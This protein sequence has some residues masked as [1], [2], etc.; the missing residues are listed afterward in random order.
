MQKDKILVA[1][2]EKSMREFLDIMLKKEG[3]KVTLASNGEEVMKL[4]EKDIFDLALVDIRMPR[5]DG[6]SVLK[7]IKSIS[8]E[9][10]V[11]VITAYASADTAIK[12]MKEGAYDYIM[13][14][15]KIEEIKLIIQNALEKKHLQNENLLLKQ[16]VRDRYHFENIIGQSSRMLD[17]YDLLEKVA[18][19]KTNILIAGESGTGKELAAKAIHYNSPRKDKP[20]VTLNCGA[21]PESLIET[22][23]FG[24]MKGAFT[25]AIST[26]KGLFEVA[27]EGTLFLDEISELPLM[28]QVKLL[29][30]LQDREFKRVG[31]T[32]DIRVDVR[33]ISATN[34]DLEEAVR[35]KQFREDLFYRLNVIQIKIPSL[36]E[37]KEDIPLLTSHFLKKYSEELGKQISQI[38]PEALRI[39]VQYD[40]PGNVRELQNIIE[41][42]VALETSQELTAQNLNSYI[43]EQLPLKRKPLDLEIPSEGVDLEKIVEDVERTLLLKALDRTK[44][45][46]KKAAELLHINF[47]SMRYRLEKYGLNNGE[48]S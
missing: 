28:M 40:Y 14:P 43:E 38:S 11:I 17:L 44:G 31:G 48:E 46:K 7:R 39:L 12:A 9:T 30:V 6:I 32:E 4:I 36:R 37:H 8:P 13:K 34:K 20:F 35:E 26:K 5:Q 22:E 19:T 33:I 21:I 24:H 29:R 3:Y 1:D 18:P 45:I 42:A 10:V 23:L 15:F 47:R 16:V 41:R 25:D 2:D 27:D